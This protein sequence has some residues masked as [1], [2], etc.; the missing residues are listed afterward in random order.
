MHRMKTPKEYINEPDLLPKAGAYIKNYGKKALLVGSETSF[1]AVGDAFYQS[2]MDNGIAYQ[3]YAFSGFPTMAKAEAI[4][5]AFSEEDVVVGVG[6]G[7]VIDTAK[8]AAT[9]KGAP[10]V[11]VPTIAATCASWAAVSIIYN[12]KGEFEKGFFNTLGPLLILA[13]T[14]VLL[15]APKRYLF[16]GVIDTFAKWYEIHPYQQIEPSS[17]ILP[18]I[19]DV[20]WRALQVLKQDVFH[21]VAL[22]GEGLV[23]EEA[24]RTVDAIIF[25]A[26]LTGSLETNLL[27][28]GIAHPFY[29]VTSFVKETHH[30]LHGERVGY[31]L[32]LQQVLEKKSR[33]E[34]V[35][36][37][38]LF[39]AYDNLLTLEDFGMKGDKEKVRFIAEAIWS[40]YRKQ[41]NH[42]G[43][44][45]SP[46]EIEA[47][48]YATDEIILESGYQTTPG[49]RARHEH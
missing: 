5:Q 15:D 40:G 10:T 20:A 1:H 35:E 31:G 46:E 41:L 32:L 28:Q 3:K 38:G 24:I 45:Y 29:N 25:H 6:G 44:G 49:K 8:V 42:L 9:L 30:L 33:K 14:R 12:D 48:I 26:G 18:I 17:G 22:H 16:A 43:Y 47:A 11:T 23:G 27:Y 19:S 7:R 21:A 36:T 13:D 37:I 34:I 2:L 39:S 4:A